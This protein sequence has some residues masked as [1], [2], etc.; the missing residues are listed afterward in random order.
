M[1]DT[2]IRRSVGRCQIGRCQIAKQMRSLARFALAALAVF[3]ISRAAYGDAADQV[4]DRIVENWRWSHYWFG[5][6]G[7]DDVY[8]E[9]RESPH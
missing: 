6:T 7:L 5:K 3:A 1:S 8:A 9:A 2:H 4:F